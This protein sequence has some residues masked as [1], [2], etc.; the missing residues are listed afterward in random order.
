M[1]LAFVTPFII[2]LIFGAIE[3]ARMA[4]IKQSLTYAA[5][6]A[7]RHAS[8]VT[9][10]SKASCESTA[11]S[12]L[13]GVVKD[14]DQNVQIE[15]TPSFETRPGSGDEVIVTVSVKCEDVSWLPPVFFAGAEV[16]ATSSLHRE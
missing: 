11:K 3:L 5:Q 14:V 7:C 10:T 13:E 15:V 1:E 16:S 12:M 8:L 4:M 9:T 2:V 6:T